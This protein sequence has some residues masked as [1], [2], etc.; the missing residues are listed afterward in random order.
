MFFTA[1]FAALEC[2]NP[3]PP[4]HAYDAPMFTIEPGVFAAMCRRP[5]SREQKNVP[6]ITI[7]VTARQPFGLRSSAGTGKLPAALLTSVPASPSASSTASNVALTCSASRMSHAV[8][9]ALPPACSTASTPALRWPSPRLTMATDAP[10]R[11]NST[12]IALPSPVPPPVTITTSSLKVPAGRADAPSAG[13]SGRPLTPPPRT[14][15]TCR[16][17]PSTRARR[18]LRS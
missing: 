12:A 6:S 8:A 13:G 11:A 16:E 5:N 9:K 15:S 2:A 14:G 3:G 18:D 17:R 4:V 1:A 7:C 10:R